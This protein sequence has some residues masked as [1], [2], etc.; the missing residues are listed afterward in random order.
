MY[1]GGVRFDTE[2]G[3]SRVYERYGD[4]SPTDIYF[5]TLIG[6][7]GARGFGS[8]SGIPDVDE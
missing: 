4:V 7:A 3:G 1:L 6:G 8:G 5:K 2:S